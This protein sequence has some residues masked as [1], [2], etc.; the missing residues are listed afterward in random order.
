MRTSAS[1]SMLWRCIIEAKEQSLFV[2]LLRARDLKSRDT[3]KKYKEGKLV[4]RR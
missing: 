2:L 3:W 4:G 1:F